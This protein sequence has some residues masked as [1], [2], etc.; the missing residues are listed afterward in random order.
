MELQSGIRQRKHIHSILSSFVNSHVDV[1]MLSF[2]SARTVWVGSSCCCPLFFHRY[3]ES[4]FPCQYLDTTFQ[5]YVINWVLTSCLSGVS[6]DLVQAS[7]TP[8]LKL[9]RFQNKQQKEAFLRGE[10]CHCF[11]VTLEQVIYTT[12]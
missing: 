8:Y 9:L 1:T 4:L 12:G 6:P 11:L 2:N 10:I 3:P 5:P 7:Q